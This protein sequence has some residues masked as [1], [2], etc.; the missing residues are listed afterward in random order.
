[1]P[2]PLQGL[3]ALL[4]AG[5]MLLSR[6]VSEVTPQNNPDDLLLVNR[7]WRISADYKPAVRVSQ[8]QGQVRRLTDE[9]ATHPEAMFEACHAETG[10]W[11]ISVSGYRDYE[12]QETIWKRKLRTVH[13]DEAA[14]D[15]YVAR[16]GASEH[17]TGLTMDVGQRGG[18]DN[19]GDGFADS[20]AGQWMRE[21]AW[22]Y[23]FI[24][25]YDEGWEDITGYSYE[26]WH[27]RYVGEEHAARIHALNIPL[28]EYLQI[29]R[30]E[31]LLDILGAGEDE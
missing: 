16:P 15:E 10:K 21:N 19:L 13:G 14:A 9:A 28:E 25:R 26:P 6:P 29:V 30:R 20:A 2:N 17:Q 1:M 5:T 8:V 3:A 11:M 23:G 7:E 27:F 18:N 22:R 4:A 24:L 31:R 12:K